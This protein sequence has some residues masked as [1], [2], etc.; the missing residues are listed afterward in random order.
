MALWP[1][2]IAE[3]QDADRSKLKEVIVNMDNLGEAREA[4]QGVDVVF[5]TLGTTRKAAGSAEAFV[6]VSALTRPPFRMLPE[7]SA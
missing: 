4:F 2:F 5:C 1:S 7:Y 3:A 6:K